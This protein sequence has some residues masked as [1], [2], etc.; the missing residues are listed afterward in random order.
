MKERIKSID[1]LRGLA[2][3]AVILIHTTTRTLEASHFN[4]VGFSWTLFLNQVVRFAVPLFIIISGF[5]LE[6]SAR[7]ENYWSFIK[8]RFSKI[9][10]PYIFWSLFYY[11][12]V[13]N[14]NNDSLVKVFLTG[15][16]SYQLYFI[17][18]LLVFYL[19]FPLVHKR[20]Q[21]FSSKT[22]FIVISAVGLILL[23]KNYYIKAID[24]GDEVNA[25]ILAY[26]YFIIGIL[27]A[28]N[29]EFIDKFVNKFKL[30]LSI[31]TV[32]LAFYVFWE[33]RSRYLLTG[34]YLSYYSQWRPSVFFYSLLIGLTFYYIFEHTK[35]RDSFVS[36]FSKH[37]FFAFFV[38]VSVLETIWKFIGIKLF[39]VTGT[40]GGKI[41]FDPLF[42]GTVAFISFL[43]SKLVHKI[44]KSV[45]LL[46]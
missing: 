19:L 41:I 17:P 25:I 24:L 45:K 32:L 31:P 12:A 23:C 37:S 20:I 34:N 5:V 13:Y 44:P 7:E 40:I 26:P 43:I 9:F 14:N 1:S 29:K 35:F 27:A 22:I 39:Y 28:R 6:T 16:A 36:R 4:L 38:H 33:G 15:N 8:R 21:K 11:L 46:G 18:A 42:F 30:F 3:L 10:I 2:I